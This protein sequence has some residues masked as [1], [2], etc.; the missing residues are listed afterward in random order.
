MRLEASASEDG[1]REGR[2]I[3]DW[4]SKALVGVGWGAKGQGLVGLRCHWEGVEVTLRVITRGPVEAPF[5]G[6]TPVP[7]PWIG[8]HRHLTRVCD[9][10]LD[11][12]EFQ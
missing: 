12:F 6:L 7:R 4:P 8:A 9:Q 10:C 11:K 5:L 2:T 3:W 1:A